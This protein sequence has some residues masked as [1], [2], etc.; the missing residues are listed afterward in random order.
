MAEQVLPPKIDRVVIEAASGLVD[1]RFESPGELR[2]AKAPEGAA[3]GC[4]RVD[5][6]GVEHDVR[7]SVR[8]RRRV[9]ALLNDTGPDVGVGSDVEVRVALHGQQRA[10]PLEANAHAGTRIAATDGAKGFLDGQGQTYRSRNDA[11]KR[12]HDRFEFR[13]CLAAKAAAEGRDDDSNPAEGYGEHRGQLGAYRVRV[14]G[15]GPDG[16]AALLAPLGQRRVRLHGV[17]LHS[18]EAIDVLDDQLGL[19]KGVDTAPPHQI[20]LMADVGS[21][22]RFE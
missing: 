3:W 14:L 15:R 22:H 11:R 12:A 13:V 7:H 5:G 9:G 21:R 20:K 19:V 10:V 18:R 1:E 2:H 6:V 4:I 16:Q 8:S 17:V